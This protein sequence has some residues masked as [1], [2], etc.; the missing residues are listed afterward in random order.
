MLRMYYIK[1]IIILLIAELL[2]C[3]P[4]ETKHLKPTFNK[5]GYVIKKTNDIFLPKDSIII[6]GYIKDISAMKSLNFSN[7]KLGCTSV[8][9]DENG[10]YIIKA[11][12]NDDLSFLTCYSIGYRT[13]ETERLILTKYKLININFFMIEDDR[14]LINCE[15]LN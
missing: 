1:G 9:S 6:Q 14:P 3:K 8:K 2:G 10:F 13:I 12:R 5:G 7:V 4:I 11:K 15:G